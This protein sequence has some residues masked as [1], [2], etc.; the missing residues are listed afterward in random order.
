MATEMLD[1]VLGHLRKAAAQGTGDLTDGELLRRFGEQHDAAAFTALVQRHGPLVLGVCRRVLHHH[2]DAEDA[3]QATFLVLARNTAKIRKGQAVGSWL[4][5]VAYR[6]ALQARR[7]AAR[8]RFHEQKAKDMAQGKTAREPAWRDLQAVLDQE[9]RGLGEVYRTAFV[10]CCLE[11]KS[12]SEAARELGLKEGTL[13]GRLARA[14]QQLRQ[15]LARR[16]VTL[17]AALALLALSRTPVAAALAHATVRAAVLDAAGQTAAAG[18]S[19]GAVAL[20]RAVGKT[21][22]LTKAAVALAVLA[23]G[24]AVFGAGLLAHRALASPQAAASPAPAR[25]SEKP[26]PAGP[27]KAVARKAAQ[28]AGQVT[29]R[30][31]DPEGKAVKGAQ[32]FLI[33]GPSRSRPERTLS[34]PDGGFHFALDPADWKVSEEYRV[35]PAVVAAAPGYGPSVVFPGKTGAP[36]GL[37]LRLVKDDVPIR[38]R[39]LNLEGKPVAGVTARVTSFRVPTAADLTPWLKVLRTNPKGGVAVEYRFFTGLDFPDLAELFPPVRSGADGR[40][41]ITGVG[42]ER[43][44]DLRLEGPTIETSQVRVR[45][46]PGATYRASEE[47][48]F[49]RRAQI[50]YYGAAFDHIVGPTVPVVGTVRDR[51]TGKPLAGVTVRSTRL[52]GNSAFGGGWIQTTTDRNGRYRLT[53]L[54]KTADNVLAAFPPDGQPYK[55]SAK[56]P[57]DGPPYLASTKRVGDLSGLKPVTV[58]LALKRGVRVTGRI[59]DR[60]TGKPVP[61][62]QVSYFYFADNP[63]RKEYLPLSDWLGTGAREDGTFR[64]A[65]LPGRGLLAVRAWRDGYLRG[66]GAEKIR[67]MDGQECFRTYPHYCHAPDYHTLAEINPAKGARSLTCDLVLDPGRTLTGTVLGPDGKPLA[68]T[69]GFSLGAGHGEEAVKTARFTVRN[70]RPG[71]PRA[72]TFLHP[73]R[74][75]AGFALVRGDEKKPLTIKLRPWATVTGRLLDANGLPA[76]GMRLTFLAGDGPDRDLFTGVTARLTPPDKDGKF[77]VEGLV[78]G[79]KYTLAAVKDFRITAQPLSGFSPKP[80]EAKNLGDVR[81]NR[82]P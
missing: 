61:R 39:V 66:L 20:A 33:R 42:R 27:G 9:I 59:T 21:M 8:R 82:N 58:D 46:R 63:Y 10:L 57:A 71:H 30:V 77:R 79:L 68:G 80:G 60:A 32:V 36:R 7:A 24:L 22:F 37:T 2:H 3:F 70:L 38:G 72:V 12:K 14:R 16:G 6:T 13:S 25:R 4:H 53:G 54:P 69:R 74:R 5:G 17:T 31:V 81:A 76:R 19:A 15:R 35:E 23:A 40:F 73:S 49:P 64:L 43:L 44:I 34:A 55:T 28:A 62:A 75:L 29:G 78:P 56:R 18:V 26:P 47:A 41:R 65:V 52:P 1:T 67:G 11:G 45:T 51:D 48:L 50:I